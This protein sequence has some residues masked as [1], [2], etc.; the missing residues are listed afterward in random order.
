M[1]IKRQ[2]SFQDVL[3]LKVSMSH[4]SQQK[5]IHRMLGKAGIMK[6]SKNILHSCDA[7]VVLLDSCTN[8]KKSKMGFFYLNRGNTA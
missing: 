4:Q 6:S 5:L 3:N 1:W 2:A 8:Y 7:D